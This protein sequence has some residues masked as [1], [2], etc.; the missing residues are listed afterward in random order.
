[1]QWVRRLIGL[2]SRVNVR[3][4]AVPRLLRRR[5]LS[6]KLEKVS[7]HHHHLCNAQCSVRHYCPERTMHVSSRVAFT[8]SK[9]VSSS[10]R[11]LLQANLKQSHMF[12]SPIPRKIFFQSRLTLPDKI[13][14]VAYEKQDHKEIGQARHY[15]VGDW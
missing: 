9:M 6:D 4:G 3:G 7:P 10:S 15:Q 2:W 12:E 1:M 11:N 13:Q 5:G 8:C 14:V